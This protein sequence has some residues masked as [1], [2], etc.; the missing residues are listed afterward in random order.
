MRFELTANATLSY[1]SYLGSG[2]KEAHLWDIY[3][4]VIGGKVGGSILF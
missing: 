1:S 4:F 3:A 2:F